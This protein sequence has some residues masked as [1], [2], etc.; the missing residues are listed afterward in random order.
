M[1]NGIIDCRYLSEMRHWVGE[2]VFTLLAEQA[3]DNLAAPLAD[4]TAAWR[5]SDTE[6]FRDA[7]HRL[8]GAAASMGCTALST[9]AEGM[10]CDTRPIEAVSGAEMQALQRLLQ[11]SLLALGAFAIQPQDTP[12]PARP[13]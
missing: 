1:A 3:A 8:K 9:A 10:M 5:R 6:S 13:Q 12:V 7:T 4:L 11:A 2:A